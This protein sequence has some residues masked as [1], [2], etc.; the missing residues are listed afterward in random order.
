MIDPTFPPPPADEPEQEQ[1]AAFTPAAG[2]VVRLDDPEQAGEPRYG[3]FV[4]E[5]V[6]VPLTGAQR[7]ELP[8]YPAG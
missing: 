1:A 2:D 7:Y 5:S 6:V 8:L 4:A 3:L